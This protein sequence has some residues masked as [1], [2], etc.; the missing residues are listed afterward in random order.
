MNKTWQ[1]L[2]SWALAG[3]AAGSLCEIYHG[4]MRVAW[5]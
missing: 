2:D 3:A 5:R 1:P 4:D